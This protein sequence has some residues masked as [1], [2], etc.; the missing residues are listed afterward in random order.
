MTYHSD[1]RSI[2][3]A[4]GGVPF[5]ILGL[6]AGAIL[7][8]ARR[9]ENWGR[10]WLVTLAIVYYV[11]STLPAPLLLATV[12]ARGYEPLAP[13]PALDGLTTVVVLSGGSD[14]VVGRDREVGLL[15]RESLSRALEGV[16]V[17]QMVRDARIVATGSPD[18]RP[19]GPA[20]IAEALVMRSALAS[21]GVPEDRVLLETQGRNTREQAVNVAALLRPR[22]VSRVVLVTSAFHMRRAESAFRAAGLLAV[23]AVSTSGADD[24]PI[25]DYI[26]PSLGTLQ[27]STWVL[28][29]YVGLAYYRMRGWLD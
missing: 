8:L 3:N 4:F 2:V 12:L 6:A 7:L 18:E 25:A 5:L 15:G 23:P 24:A 17:F 26:V 21:M 9:T 20:P 10:R 14:T 13:G 29:E 22:G 1:M 19:D 16:R 11:M 27:L 28:H